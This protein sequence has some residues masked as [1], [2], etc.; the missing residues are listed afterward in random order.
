[1]ILRIPRDIL[2][3]GSHPVGGGIAPCWWGH[4]G[5][6]LDVLRIPRDNLDLGSHPVGGDI[7]GCP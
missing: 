6:S 1:M 4:C 7:V 3:L 2:D 5:M